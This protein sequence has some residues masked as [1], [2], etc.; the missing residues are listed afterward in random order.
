M[1][2]WKTIAG[3]HKEEYK[4]RE[5]VLERT[6]HIAEVRLK[7]LL[8]GFGANGSTVCCPHLPNGTG[9]EYGVD[10]N[11]NELEI[12]EISRFRRL[13]LH[14]PAA[15]GRSGTCLADELLSEEYQSDGEWGRS[16]SN[17]TEEIN[18]NFGGSNDRSEMKGYYY[19]GSHVG[20]DKTRL[21]RAVSRGQDDDLER[22]VNS[23]GREIMERL[24]LIGAGMGWN[25]VKIY[26]AEDW[27]VF[28][29]P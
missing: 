2:I 5:R 8:A 16:V 14:P 13:I 29:F 26:S 6:A 24:A 15:V 17:W 22:I 27:I 7:T 19:I 10:R 4:K 21:S 11:E 12:S 1:Q 3:Q 25:T 28:S 9:N 18:D 23:L 20:D